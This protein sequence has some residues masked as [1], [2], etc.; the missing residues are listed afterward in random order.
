MVLENTKQTKVRIM[1]SE[2]VRATGFLRD[3]AVMMPS[4]H[5]RTSRISCNLR[6]AQE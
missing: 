2:E 5:P 6:I 4:P 3:L 1:I